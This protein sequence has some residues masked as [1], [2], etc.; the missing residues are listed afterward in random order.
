LD[1]F[2]DLL[3][4]MMSTLTETL[5]YGNEAAASEALELL[6]ELAGTEPRFLKR[7]IVEVVGTML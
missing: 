1:K 7:Q 6:I 3:T 2:R 5:N 4:L